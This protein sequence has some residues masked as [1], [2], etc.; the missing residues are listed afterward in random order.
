MSS[1]S[2]HSESDKSGMSDVGEE[3]FRSRIREC[4]DDVETDGLFYS[5][6]HDSAYA[7]PGL[8]VKGIGLIGL[9]LTHR[10]AEALAN[11]HLMEKEN[12]HS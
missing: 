2:Q 12:R 8:Q 10:D 3:E 11:S 7:N 9:P 6:R 5:F 1:P 4:L